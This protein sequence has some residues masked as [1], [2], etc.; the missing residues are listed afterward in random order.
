MQ[1]TNQ[2]NTY[3]TNLTS[4]EFVSK[5]CS[6]ANHYIT[7][8]NNTFLHILSEVRHIH[9]NR[10]IDSSKVF[11]H[12]LRTTSF[13]HVRDLDITEDKC[14]CSSLHELMQNSSFCAQIFHLNLFGSFCLTTSHIKSIGC[15]FT[16]LQTLRFTLQFAA[17]FTEQ[18]NAIC[19]FI[20]NDMRS[21]LRYLHVYFQQDI[22]SSGSVGPTEL[23][24]SDWL[25]SNHTQLAHIEQIDLNRNELS[26]W[27]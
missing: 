15:L 10:Y 1:L 18:L 9:F 13:Q 4:L 3:L 17:S 6:H 16:N 14:H 26:V 24:L 21:H 12:L 5:H 25:G 7:S 8:L 19:Q 23:E 20:L 27:M 2:M 11:K 22:L